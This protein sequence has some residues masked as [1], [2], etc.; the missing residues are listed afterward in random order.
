[1]FYQSHENQKNMY[2]SVLT[3][4]QEV[5][6]ILFQINVLCVFQKSKKTALEPKNLYTLV[7][8][9]ISTKF[10]ILIEKIS[11]CYSVLYIIRKTE[12]FR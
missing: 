2:I 11:R 7:A 5:I 4:K 3:T 10:V 6:L 1:M 9:L 8:L 12:H